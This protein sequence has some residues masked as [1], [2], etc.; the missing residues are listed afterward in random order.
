MKDNIIFVG[1]DVSKDKHDICIKDSN[2][3]ELTRRFQILNTKA[4][5]NVLY[6]TIDKLTKT[7]GIRDVIFGMEATG[8]Y[9]LPLFSALK[10][11][12]Y[13][14]RLYNPIQTHGY[15]KMEVR[16]TKTDSIDASIIAD[17][18]RY[19]ELP[20][21]NSFQDLRLYQL[22][23]LTRSRQRLVDNRTK[24]K[25]QLIRDLDMTWPGYT[26]IM[27]KIFGKTSMA[28]LK[29][30]SVPS[31]I[32]T[33]T[34]EQFYELIYEVSRGQITSSKALRIYNHARD[35]LTVPEVN[36]SASF[37]IKMLISQIEMYD[38]QILG[39]QA[40][41]NQMMKL[42]NSKVTSIPGISDV[43][44]A[45]ILGEIGNIDRFS[46]VKKLIAFAGLD[47]AIRKSGRQENKTGPISKRGSPL[48]RHALFLAANVARQN[49]ETLKRY[50]NKK[51]SEGKHYY[52]ALNATAAKVLRIV[53]W[54]LKNDMEYKPLSFN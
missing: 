10:R 12:G 28:I 47:P 42:I 22:R 5:L 3:N 25:I 9:Y 1:I 17:M 46:N 29:Q 8:I 49:D 37:E 48:L 20:L 26:V 51:I 39:I 4:D 32:T 35:I 16:K 54:V 23:E 13:P 33:G 21:A 38:K 30:Y 36:L 45:A 31:E 15:R 44:G 2:G 34:F 18:L 53:F 43:L 24:I 19:S 6:A 40:K 7:K 11:D 50:F 27:P 41:I 52:S 14:I